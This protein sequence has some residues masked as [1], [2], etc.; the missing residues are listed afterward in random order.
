L[1][2]TYEN[3]RTENIPGRQGTT[4]KRS[5]NVPGG[6]GKVE[7]L[8]EEHVEI[9]LNEATCHQ[10]NIQLFNM[11]KNCLVDENLEISQCS[12]QNSRIIPQFRVLDKVEVESFVDRRDAI[13][14]LSSVCDHHGTNM[15]DYVRD[16]SKGTMRRSGPGYFSIDSE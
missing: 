10:N 3:I 8:L 11:R 9:F 6:E 7:P 1:S 16:V 12:L 15:F 5:T 14:D 2:R 13:R 4:E